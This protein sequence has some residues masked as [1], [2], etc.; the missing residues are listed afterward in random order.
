[1]AHALMR[2]ASAPMPTLVRDTLSPPRKRVEMSLDTAD[3]SVRVTPVGG[4]NMAQPGKRVE[5]SLDT[6]RMSACATS[7]GVV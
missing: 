6:A 5:M 1:V 7:V 2:A 3:T 4:D